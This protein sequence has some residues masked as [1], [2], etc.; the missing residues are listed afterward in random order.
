MLP[1]QPILQIYG[2]YLLYL[3][4]I[5]TNSAMIDDLIVYIPMDRRFALLG[6]DSL[7]DRTRGAALFVDISGF[8]ALTE[9]LVRELGAQRG[10]EELTRYLNLVYDAIIDELHRYGGS[11][12]AFAG[13]AITCWIDQDSG[14]HATAAALAMQQFSAVATPSGGTI[15]LTMKAAMATDAVRHFLV[16]DSTQRVKMPPFF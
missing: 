3:S 13:D 15:S 8:T 4:I 14:L 11:V 12:I 6:G 9:A 7:A 10:A 1:R 16:G 5:T 2:S